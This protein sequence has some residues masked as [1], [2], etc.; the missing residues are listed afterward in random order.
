MVDC[1]TGC[2]H[3]PLR[4]GP[5]TSINNS[6]ESRRQRTR[7]ESISTLIHNDPVA[8][9]DHF[10]RYRP[11]FYSQILEF[12]ISCFAKFSSNFA[13]FREKQ[14]QNLGEIFTISRNTKPKLGAHFCY[15]GRINSLHR[16]YSYVMY[17]CTFLS[18]VTFG[19]QGRVRSVPCPKPS[20]TPPLHHPPPPLLPLPP[21]PPPPTTTPHK[22]IPQ[23]PSPHSSNPTPTPPSLSPH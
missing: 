16:T 1:H 7:T 4:I 15:F 6:V 5:N 10:G 17:N 22:Q 8:H 23:T 20:H 21:L 9:Q 18:V 12:L 14:N 11:R 3:W 2:G 13:K 19:R